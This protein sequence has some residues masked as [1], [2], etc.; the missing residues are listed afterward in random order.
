M[1][2]TRDG[3]DQRR[4]AAQLARKLEDRASAEVARPEV[5]RFLEAGVVVARAVADGEDFK[6][7]KFQIQ[8][9]TREVM[10]AGVVAAV[11]IAV[12]AQET[13]NAKLECMAKC[14]S[15]FQ[16]C[17]ADGGGGTNIP[18]EALVECIMRHDSCFASCV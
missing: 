13:E 16:A 6:S 11:R 10:I 4:R 9:A 8:V 5:Q 18:T 12:D 2:E 15:D 3:R 7:E 14:G 17:V 1:A